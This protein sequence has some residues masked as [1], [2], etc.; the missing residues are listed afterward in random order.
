MNERLLHTPEGVRDIYNSEY[1]KK[2]KLQD[3]MNNVLMLYGY[4]GIQTPSFE[5]F[6]I[7]NQERGTVPSNHMYKFFD[8]EGNTLVLRPDITPSIARAVSKYYN[9]EDLAMR[10]SYIGNTFIN[11][12]SLQGKMKETTQLGAELVNDNSV[13]ADA[14]MVAL[15]I[16]LLLE[17]GLENFQIDLGH[18]GFFKGLIEEAGI[19]EDTELK[20]R[21]LIEQKNN[22]GVEELTDNKALERLPYLFGQDNILEEAKNL[23]NNKKA[24]EAIARLEKIYATLDAYGFQKYVTFDLGML[25]EYEYYTGVIFRGYTYGTGDAVVKGGRYDNLLKQ[26]GKNA[27]AVGLAVVVDELMLALSRQKIDILLDD[28]RTM[29]LYKSPASHAAIG[30]AATLRGQSVNIVMTKKDS[31]H[32]MEDYISYCRKYA[33]SSIMYLEDAKDI[34]VVDV[35]DGTVKMMKLSDVSEGK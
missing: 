7:F 8:R 12:S 16:N 27:A 32:D 28:K 24:L 22:F 20:L 25:T 19:D 29:V 11:N 33:I 34:K 17:A 13:N 10:F 1:A 26:F 31:K 9:E 18:V 23:T 21:A 4:E 3:Q 2:T 30:L 5:F 15:A 35:I 14:E 6:D